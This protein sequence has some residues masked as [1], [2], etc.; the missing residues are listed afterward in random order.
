MLT[1]QQI[2][3]YYP[4]FLRDRKRSILREYLQYKI[5]EIIFSSEYAGKLVFLGG[6]ALRI[7]YGSPR[8][9]EDLDFDNIGITQEEFVS[10]SDIIK[11]GLQREGLGVEITTGFKMA[12]R[13]HV[14]FPDILFS[15]NLT[16]HKD[17][18]ILIHIDV[19]PHGFDYKPERKV[20]SNFDVVTAVNVVSRDLLLSM[21]V[22]AVFGRKRSKGRD[23]FDIVFLL[24]STTPNYNYLSSKLGIHNADELRK[25]L[26]EQ[27]KGIDIEE[28]SREVGP[29][30][31]NA[32]DKKR[33]ELFAE[34]IKTARLA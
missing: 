9:S 18:K 13:C 34:I 33:I 5:L 19:A 3:E 30:L 2:I 4:P 12:Y 11:R 23:Y 14:R 27:C 22:G 31:F 20:L 25:R 32:S 26:T 29:F 15:Y 24:A 16:S 7:V 21:K 28:L 1:L 8:F 6:T 10:L 17:E